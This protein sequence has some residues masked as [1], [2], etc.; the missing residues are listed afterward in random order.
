MADTTSAAFDD[1]TPARWDGMSL[2]SML[3]RMLKRA[4]VSLDAA[5]IAVALIL[6]GER[7]RVAFSIFVSAIALLIAPAAMPV[8]AWVTAVVVWERVIWPWLGELWLAGLKRGRKPTY[9][10]LELLNVLGGGL[11]AIFPFMAWTWAAPLG[12]VLATAWMSGTAGYL[13]VYYGRH[14]NLMVANGSALVACALLAP[15]FAAGGVTR[16]SLLATAVLLCLLVAAVLFGRDRIS[17]RREL[18]QA[19]RASLAKTQFLA[20]MSA[21]LRVP[22]DSIVGYA[23]LIEE[24]AAGAT[25]E[26]ARRIRLSAQQMLRVLNVILDVSRLEMGVANLLREKLDISAVLH[27]LEEAAAP[28]AAAN[29]SALRLLETG[30]LG[31]AI[32]DHVRLHQCLMQLLAN[33]LHAAPGADVALIAS[34]VADTGGDI[35]KFEV[36]DRGSALTP[37]QQR[38][39]FEPFAGA[40]ENAGLSLGFVRDIARLMG[41]DLVCSSRPGAGT[42]FTLWL[43]AGEVNPA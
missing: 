21:E 16:F 5:E 1:P 7:L 32:L 14:Q 34:R 31:E 12:P 23:E 8:F 2:A 4:A 13:T 41:G 6:S 18:D 17:M 38:R 27:G 3:K 26:D 30:P 20:A 39:I 15:S 11:Y 19:E 24:E 9:L 43:Q 22:L 25:I 33:A 36:V 28:M 10:G 40:V 42:T 37:D 29:G 35:L